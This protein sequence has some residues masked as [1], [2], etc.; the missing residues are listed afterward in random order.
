MNDS[1]SILLAQDGSPGLP[2]WPLL[3]ILGLVFYM[4]ILGP[5]RRKRQ[6]HTLMMENLKKNDQVVTIGG[7]KGTVTNVKDDEV[8]IRIDESNN[9]RIR[10]LK[11]SIS[12]I[13]LG[14][15]GEKSV[16]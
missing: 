12:R 9:T 2:L 14:D 13:D 16:D 4:M 8:T 11:S 1:I 10:V 5:D 7:I 3:V 15:S 6:Q